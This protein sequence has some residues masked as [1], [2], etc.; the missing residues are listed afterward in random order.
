[1][2]QLGDYTIHRKVAEGGMGE[3]YL[4]SRSGIR[5]FARQ[6][7][8]KRISRRLAHQ[9]AYVQM[10]LQEA[11]IA[12][13]LDHPNVVQVHELV[14]KNGDYFLVMEYVPGLSLSRCLESAEGPL[15]L[16]V[17]IQVATQV[18]AGLHFVHEKQDDEG[19]SLRLVHRDVSPPNILLS[20]WGAVKLTDFGIAKYRVSSALSQVGVI[21]GKF[22]YLAP[23]QV[24]GEAVDRRTD[25][26]SLGLVLYEMTVGR[27][28]YRGEDAE[29]LSAVEA[30]HFTPPEQIVSGYPGDLR[31]VLM[32]M[33]SYFPEGRYPSCK[34][35][36]R[37]LAGLLAGRGVPSSSE[38]VAS[39]VRERMASE[40]LQLEEASPPPLPPVPLEGEGPFGTHQVHRPGLLRLR[41]RAHGAFESLRRLFLRHRRQ[42][43]L[44][45]LALGLLL[46]S[47][48][49]FI[50][51][52]HVPPSPALPGITPADALDHGPEGAAVTD[53][54]DES[55]D[56]GPP[57]RRRRPSERSR[58]RR[59]AVRSAAHDT[60]THEVALISEPVADVY[61]GA[62]RLGRTPLRVKLPARR[63][64]LRFVAAEVGLD[65]GRTVDGRASR[66]HLRFERSGR[67]RF[68]LQPGLYVK[69]D[70]E[71]VGRTPLPPLPVYEGR[72]SVTIIDPFRYAK[73]SHVITV[74]D[75]V[76]SIP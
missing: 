40:D 20:S 73:R 1:M 75:G 31:A 42:S 39:F 71:M 60:P 45:L 7:A 41:V 52:S 18:A 28:A 36:E 43:G 15:P 4:A 59:R 34:E 46:A 48:L 58:R 27:R 29:V 61:L 56:I 22:S 33:L 21:K 53:P 32:Q 38:L 72:H 16:T 62:K 11:R 76:V 44:A 65:A 54:I 5:G 49:I 64:K 6:V 74:T 30:G 55:D 69:V 26:Y 70:G 23:E 67:L 37:D 35:L 2:E 51:I 12:A 25:I 19:R 50:W 10:F 8:I 66:A 13:L 47:A 57:P 14:E 24:R 9:E 63:V 68:E 17:A 3:I